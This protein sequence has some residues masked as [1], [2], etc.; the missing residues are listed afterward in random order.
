MAWRYFAVY[1]SLLTAF[2]VIIYLAFPETKGLTIEEVSFLLD[3]EMKDGRERTVGMFAAHEQENKLSII[4]ENVE[5]VGQVRQRTRVRVRDSPGASSNHG[6]RQTRRN[7]SFSLPWL[8]IWPFLPDDV[9][10]AFRASL[11]LTH[12]PTETPLWL[13]DG[14]TI[15]WALLTRTRRQVRS[16]SSFVSRQINVFARSTVIRLLPDLAVG[17]VLPPE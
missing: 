6:E 14:R 1:I 13:R 5:D 10:F 3:L 11:L 12:S 2:L 7:A 4:T 9:E 17:S 15:F 8:G 16:S